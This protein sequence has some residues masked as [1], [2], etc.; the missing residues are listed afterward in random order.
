MKFI[1]KFRER[2]SV[3]FVCG[4]WEVKNWAIELR[5]R[6]RVQ[7][8]NLSKLGPGFYWIAE[9]RLQFG[10]TKIEWMSQ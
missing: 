9:L 10:Y 1:N 8:L 7:K 2:I 5:D 6:E 4:T 3:K